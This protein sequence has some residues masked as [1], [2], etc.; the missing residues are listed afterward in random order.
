VSA[1][2]GDG[3]RRGRGAIGNP[4]GRFESTVRERTDDGWGSGEAEP[5]AIA[6]RL[7]VDT[8]VRVITYNASPDVP[9]D[10]SINPYRGCE[11][12]CAYCFARPTHAY[13]G[14]SPGLDFE[15]RLY[16]KPDAPERLRAELAAPGYA[17]A[18]IALGVNTDAYQ[19]VERR[20]RLTRAIL[21]VLADCRHPVCIVTK[22]ALVQRDLDLLGPMAD[23]GLTSVTVSLT[24]LDVGLSRR[25]EPRAAAPHRR[26]ETIA[27]VAAA[28]VPVA[29]LV[30]PLIPG[31][32]DHELE[33]LLEAG[34]DAG[35]LEAGYITLRLPHELEGL[36]E[37][38]LEHH[39]PERAAHVLSLIRQ[40]HGGKTYDPTWGRRMRGQGPLADLLAQRFRLACR[41]LGLNARRLDLRCDRF[42]PP[43]PESRQLTLF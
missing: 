13:L 18:P 26:L 8:A 31:V 39:L 43:R 20:L 21:E 40:L 22:S 16:Y 37:T 41:R 4:A 23:Q 36:F 2:L 15:T 5:E 28:G 30:A 38:W 34:R 32:N 25:M 1:S 14:L 19:P 7:G 33:S 29:V 10:R 9:F 3:P 11:H 12:G 35:A 17:C 27:A 6:T 24:T 42:T